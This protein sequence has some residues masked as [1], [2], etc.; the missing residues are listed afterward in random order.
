[1]TKRMLMG[2]IH[3]VEVLSQARRSYRTP[4]PSVLQRRNDRAFSP[5]GGGKEG[6]AIAPGEEEGRIGASLSLSK[7][8]FRGILA[9]QTQ[10]VAYSLTF[11][12]MP[13]SSPGL[14]KRW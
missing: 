7:G 14:D 12:S 3:D 9:T 4:L 1:M 11:R 10:V 13:P 6:R 2:G 8:G 5:L